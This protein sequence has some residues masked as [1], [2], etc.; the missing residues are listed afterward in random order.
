VLVVDESIKTTDV[1][2]YNDNDNDNNNDGDDDDDDDERSRE[3]AYI[4]STSQLRR[5]GPLPPGTRRTDCS[6]RRCSLSS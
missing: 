5:G 1:V 2:S 6:Y 3:K 4:C